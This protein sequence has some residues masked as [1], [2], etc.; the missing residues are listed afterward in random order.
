MV[1]IV[2]RIGENS[3]VTLSSIESYTNSWH[4]ST[5]VHCWNRPGYSEMMAKNDRMESPTLIGRK[6]EHWCGTLRASTHWP[7]QRWLAER[8]K[9][10][11]VKYSKIKQNYHLVAFAVESFGPWSKEAVDL[12]NKI[13]SNLIRVTGE[14]KSKR[15]L[16]ERI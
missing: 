9:R 10:K 13:G 12:I 1:F 14:Q 16:I 5:S 2:K 11:H 7:F 15:Y 3:F 4:L 8:N 6:V